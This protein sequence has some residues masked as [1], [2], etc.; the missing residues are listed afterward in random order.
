MKKKKHTGAP[1]KLDMCPLYSMNIVYHYRL[2]NRTRRKKMCTETNNILIFINYVFFILKNFP[3]FFHFIPAIRSFS[4]LRPSWL[5]AFPG[6]CTKTTTHLNTQLWL[7]NVH[8]YTN[9]FGYEIFGTNELCTQGFSNKVSEKN[10][11]LLNR[12]M[13]PIFFPLWQRFYSRF[14]VAFFHPLSSFFIVWTVFFSRSTDVLWVCV[15][16]VLCWLFS[17]YAARIPSTCT[18]WTT[19]KPQ[20]EIL[21]QLPDFFFL[22]RFVVLA[23]N[24]KES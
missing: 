22:S 8:C 5:D 2:P 4:A 17:Y 16:W 13:F 15:L 21:F 11:E 18:R 23:F 10:V 24:R 20:M 3:V 19:Q 9:S 6:G 12:K 1:L 7:F 14:V